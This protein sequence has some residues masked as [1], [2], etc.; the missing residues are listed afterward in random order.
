MTLEQLAKRLEE[1]A[2][3]KCPCPEC[4]EWRA[5]AAACRELADKREAERIDSYSI[6]LE[7][8]TDALLAECDE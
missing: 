1:S 8:A 6:E 5:A 7:A 3:P 4:R 2:Q